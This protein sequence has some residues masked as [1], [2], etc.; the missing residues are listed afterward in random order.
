VFVCV[1]DSSYAPIHPRLFLAGGP[2]EQMSA[3][4][5]QHSRLLAGATALHNGNSLMQRFVPA[6]VERRML[7][8]AAISIMRDDGCLQ[9]EGLGDLTTRE[10]QRA[11]VRRGFNPWPTGPP[12]PTPA[13]AAAAGTV[14][15]AATATATADALAA[16]IA[17]EGRV[18]LTSWLQIY[19]SVTP[20]AI[21]GGQVRACSLGA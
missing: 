4:S 13:A 5:A 21:Q 14:H 20:V 7:A 19:D 15:D 10:V 6:A 3:L 17:D 11:L 9:A 2:L 18:A 8:A 12:P 16:A 1:C